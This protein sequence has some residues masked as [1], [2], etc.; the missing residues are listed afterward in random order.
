[1]NIS[2]TLFVDIPLSS[3]GS[4]VATAAYLDELSPFYVRIYQN[5][6]GTWT[7]IGTNIGGEIAND[8]FG[9]SISLSSD[10]SIVAIGAPDNN[11]NGDYSGHVRVYQNYADNWVQIGE[12]IDGE[13]AGDHSGCSVSLSSSGDVVAIGASGNDGN[14]GDSGH[15]RIY[16]NISGTWTQIGNDINGEAANDHSGNSVSLSPDGDIVAVGATGNDGNGGDS[17]HVRVYQNNNGTWTQIGNDIDG[18]AT[19]D[20][21]GRSVSLSYDGPVVAIGAPYNDGNGSDAGHV[22]VYELV[23]VKID[24][25]KLHGISISPNPTKGVINFDF[26]ENNIRKITI[27]D[28]TGKMIYVNQYSISNNQLSVNL[29]NFESGI[30]IVSIQTDKEIFT[31]KIVKG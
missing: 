26:A 6:A 15:V 8:Y 5:N 23:T 2:S 20:S 9:S 30:Y 25:H 7:P 4:T 21:S 22:R 3:D 19:G 31:T 16:K 13:E 24:A 12:D 18:E 14:G 17:G 29:L 11:G 28:I 10:G 27:S 1:M